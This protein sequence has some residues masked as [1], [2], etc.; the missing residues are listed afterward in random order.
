[1]AERATTRLKRLLERP[2][3]AMAPGVADALM[4][5]LVARAGF[6]V[7][8]MT[9]NGTA[10]VRLGAPDI[11]LLTMIEMVDNAARIADSAGIPLI[12][13]ADDGYGNPFNVRRTVRAYEKAGIAALHIEDQMAP[14]RCGHFAG[15]RLIP[16]PEMAAKI[17]A[18]AD[19]REDPD[20]VIIARTDA[21]AVEGL[22]AALERAALYGEAGADALFVEAPGSLDD[23]ETIGRALAKPQVFN[24][25]TSGKTPPVSIDELGALG[26]KIAIYP[27]HVLYAALAGSR[28]L[29]AELKSTGS[30]AEARTALPSFAEYHEILGLGEIQ[31]LEARYTVADDARVGV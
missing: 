23:I 14:K 11:G 13:D 7:L 29:L 18:A 12:A 6:E 3:C 26:F 15:K 25:S 4:G 8:Y 19:A 1:M 30:V 31:E 22:S 16:A 27:N 21:I 5:R 24:M 28:K 9:G 10:A 2:G 20:L 17:K